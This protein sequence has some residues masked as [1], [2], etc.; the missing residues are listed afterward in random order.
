M[1]I[2]F[3][4]NEIRALLNTIFYYCEDY[5]DGEID[6]ADILSSQD[7]LLEALGQS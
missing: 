3:T 2:D 5:L 1:K 6:I 4:E 7:K